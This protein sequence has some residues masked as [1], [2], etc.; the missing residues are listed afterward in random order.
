MG[1]SIKGLDNLLRMPH[2]CGEQTMVTFAPDVFV[3]DYLAA[4]NQLTDDIKGKVLRYLERGMWSSFNSL[5][6]IQIEYLTSIKNDNN[7]PIAFN[8][9]E[10]LQ[11]YTIPLF[12]VNIYNTC[13]FQ[14]PYWLTCQTA[15]IYKIN[16]SLYFIIPPAFLS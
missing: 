7:D 3:T 15:A 5:N 4:T 9:L 1:P 2:G 8:K 12:C 16:I 10:F 11:M 6:L 14:L 13:C